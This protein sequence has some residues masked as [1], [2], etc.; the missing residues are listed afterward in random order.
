MQ[1]AVYDLYYILDVILEL[2][3]LGHMLNLTIKGEGI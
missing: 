3:E 1:R 2:K